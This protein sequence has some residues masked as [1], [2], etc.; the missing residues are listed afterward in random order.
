MLSIA[1]RL[2]LLCI[3]LTAHPALRCTAPTTSVPQVSEVMNL[4]GDVRG[5]VAVLV[6]DMIDTAGEAGNRWAHWTLFSTI[7]A[8]LHLCRLLWP[9]FWSVGSGG[10]GSSLEQTSNSTSPQLQP[11]CLGVASPASLLAS[12]APRHHHQRRQGAACGGRA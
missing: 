8:G 7:S 4:I 1:L 5:K 11:A 6:D 2:T 3:G 10:R 9:A 12:P